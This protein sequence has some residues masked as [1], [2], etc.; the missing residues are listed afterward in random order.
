MKK[1]RFPQGA[2][3]R[4]HGFVYRRADCD[5]VQGAE[6][7]SRFFAPQL[8]LPSFPLCRRR[9]RRRRRRRSSFPKLQDLCCCVCLW[10]ATIATTILRSGRA[11]DARRS[12][13][14][15]AGTAL[16]CA[17]PVAGTCTYPTTRRPCVADT[18]HSCVFTD[19]EMLWQTSRFAK[20][21]L[22]PDPVRKPQQHS[23]RMINIILSDHDRSDLVRS[24]SPQRSCLGFPR[25]DSSYWT[26]VSH[27]PTQRNPAQRKL[28]QATSNLRLPKLSQ[29]IDWT[30]R[31]TH[32]MLAA[33][34]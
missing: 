20:T 2:L 15:A 6:N 13:I 25:E 7:D 10:I 14:E 16:A 1:R 17:Q 33:C 29:A 22:R 32:R 30:H 28:S 12:D 19:N 18:W 27:T 24:C 3:R 5:W 23:D 9:R 4:T 21:R 34:C 26:T 11:R 31:L 8:I